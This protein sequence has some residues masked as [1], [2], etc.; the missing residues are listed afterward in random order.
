MAALAFFPWLDCGQAVSVGPIRLIP[1]ARGKLPGAQSSMS[2]AE[3]DAVLKAYADPPRKR[4]R[5]AAL[6]E[7]DDWTLGQDVDDQMLSR[8]FRAKEALTFSALADR[9]LFSFGG[10]WNAD[11]FQLIV[12]NYS[13]SNLGGFAYTTR[14]R[15]GGASNYW[16]SDE[17]AF[18]CP[19]HVYRERIDFNEHIAS[20][21]MRTDKDGWIDAIA[22]FN[23]A[24]TDAFGVAEYTE[25]IMIKSAFE[26]LLD[27]D[28]YANNFRAA[29]NTALSTVPRRSP[30]H[31][32][33][34]AHWNSRWPKAP[35]LLMAWSSEFCA[36]RGIAA[37]GT[38]GGAQFVWSERA[39]LAFASMLFP[40]VFKVLAQQE[41]ELALSD[42]DC[43][44]MAALNK[45]IAHDPFKPTASVVERG[46]HPWHKIENEIAL[47]GLASRMYP[48]L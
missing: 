22:E 29:L 45:F 37:H 11:N 30:A 31:G 12:Q 27:I 19:P 20:L 13:P 10:Y 39:H 5:S 21:L 24:N 34:V 26:R 38:K 41:G 46:N 25:M 42:A 18:V 4:V 36:Q 28:H 6:L 32:E 16:S 15:D 17:F 33:L 3:A 7:V 8:L 2:Q 48:T 43:A 35:D 40:L 44:R 23:A 14:R 9:R 47:T 1:Y